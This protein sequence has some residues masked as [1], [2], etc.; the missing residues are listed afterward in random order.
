[1]EADQ[2]MTSMH[3]LPLER[4]S[5]SDVVVIIAVVFIVAVDLIRNLVDG[6]LL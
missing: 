5:R 2:I 4:G 6:F 1:M 3:F